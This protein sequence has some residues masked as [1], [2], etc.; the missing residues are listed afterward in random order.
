MRN[1]LL[2]SAG[3]VIY[4]QKNGL[5]RQVE[6]M[7][8]LLHLYSPVLSIDYGEASGFFSCSKGL[9]QGD[10][11]SPLL[12]ILVMEALSKLINKACGWVC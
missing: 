12:F 6:E 5:P 9:R 3:E 10:P 7:D 4:L 11:L 1:V 2:D 8:L